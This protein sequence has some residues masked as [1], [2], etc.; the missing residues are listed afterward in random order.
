MTDYTCTGDDWSVIENI[1]NEPN[2]E[3]YLVSID[4]A[5]LKKR[6]LLNLLTPE[7]FVGDEVSTYSFVRGRFYLV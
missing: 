4:D 5:Y 1:I 3:R 6:E 7:E 2:E